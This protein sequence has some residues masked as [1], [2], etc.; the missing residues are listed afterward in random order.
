VKFPARGDVFDVYLE[1]DTHNF[2]PWRDR[3]PKVE[4]DG[5]VPMN[6]VTVPTPETTSISFF[7]DVLMGLGK[8]VM[9][10]GNAG[11]GKTAL[12]NG[13]LRSLNE[14][15]MYSVVNLN[16]YTDSMALQTALEGPLEK[17]VCLSTIRCAYV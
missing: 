15:F 4:Y 7:M 6:S 14:D 8:A 3:V 2:T 11:C 12:V 17:K 16:Y 9:L 10:V 13:K 5:S 1:P